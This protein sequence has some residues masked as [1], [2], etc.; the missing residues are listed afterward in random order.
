MQGYVY[1]A[2]RAGATLAAELGHSERS[3]RWTA[4]AEALREAFDAA[5]WCDELSTYAVALDGNKQP[6]RVRTSNAGQCLFTG[7]AS[8]ERARRLARNLLDR[9]LF[10]GWGVRTVADSERRYNPMG[11]HTGAVWPHDNSLIAW[12]L[13]RYGLTDNALQVLTGQFEAALHFDLQRMPELFCGFSREPGE[14]P[15]LYP[16]A[17]APQA[18]SAAAVFLLLQ[19]C[20]GLKIDSLEGQVQFT[21]PHLPESLG[22]LWIHNLQVGNASA[23]LQLVRH[24]HD[25]SVNVLRR[26]GDLQIIVVT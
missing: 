15:V 22:D 13:S 25:V 24:E 11:Y 9:D 23:D 10:S 7:I 19:A 26:E 6:C 3:A 17:C 21:R 16:V 18:W 8:P 2:R 14:G 20:L 1:A 5:F 4:Q 12:G